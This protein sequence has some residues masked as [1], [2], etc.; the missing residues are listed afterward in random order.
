M[1]NREIKLT[2]PDTL[3]SSL[4]DLAE[5]QNITR[6]QLIRDAIENNLATPS[7]RNFACRRY[8]RS[9]SR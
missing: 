1:P 9:Q 4:N 6:A 3:L 5:Q 7:H 8:S 2:V